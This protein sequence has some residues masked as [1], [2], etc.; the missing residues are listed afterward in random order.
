M[1]QNPAEILKSEREARLRAMQMAGRFV[2]EATPHDYELI[3]V[4]CPR[5]EAPGRELDVEWRMLTVACVEPDDVRR[6]DALYERLRVARATAERPLGAEELTADELLGPDGA[7]LPL[8]EYCEALR[9]DLARHMVSPAASGDVQ[10]SWHLAPTATIAETEPLRARLAF[11]NDLVLMRQYPGIFTEAYMEEKAT[12]MQASE[13]AQRALR[14]I[15]QSRP[16]W[17]PPA[18]LVRPLRQPVIAILAQ[19]LLGYYNTDTRLHRRPEREGGALDGAQS[20]AWIEERLRYY[21]EGVLLPRVARS[22]GFTVDDMFPVFKRDRNTSVWPTRALSDVVRG[23]ALPRIVPIGL[24]PLVMSHL[25]PSFLVLNP[26]PIVCGA[27]LAYARL[28]QMQGDWTRECQTAQIEQLERNMR[29]YENTLRLD[30]HPLSVH[31]RL[32]QLT[33]VHIAARLNHYLRAKEVLYKAVLELDPAL[34]ERISTAA[35]AAA[36]RALGRTDVVPAETGDPRRDDPAYDVIGAYIR[37]RIQRSRD[38]DRVAYE[39]AQAAGTASARK[40]KRLSGDDKERHSRKKRRHSHKHKREPS[41]SSSS[42]D[43]D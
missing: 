22:Y 13:M 37:E 11:A 31:V 6:D 16:D 38:T 20:R 28:R 4:L 3:P 35:R 43:Q 23:R 8:K 18:Y 39:R 14:A 30:A 24:L 5:S 19:D 29:W 36:D 25:D 7:R 9:A 40:R 10:R 34:E 42:S 26:V 27:V 15:H 21:S 32:G 12:V 33:H 1:S 17:T 41:S 2:A